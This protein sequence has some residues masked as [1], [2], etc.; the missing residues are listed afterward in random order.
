MSLLSLAI[1]VA[2]DLPR[3]GEAKFGAAEFAKE[4]AFGTGEMA[5]GSIFIA[6]G[7]WLWLDGFKR[8]QRAIE[9]WKARS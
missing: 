1:E 8:I 2:V 7:I 9:K 6:A 4:V 3:F 5:L